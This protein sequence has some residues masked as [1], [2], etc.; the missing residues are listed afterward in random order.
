[1][2]NIFNIPFTDRTLSHDK[3]YID[4][5]WV[6]ADNHSSIAVT[7]PAN[8][9]VIG[10]VPNMGQA[11][12]ARAIASAYSAFAAWRRLTA[13]ARADLLKS[14]HRLILEHISDIAK[15]ITLEEGKPLA[16]STAEVRYG[17]S[18]IE[19]FAEE[20]KRVDGQFIP[21]FDQNKRIL[22]L[23]QPVG[24]VAAITP[25]NFPLA[26]ATRKLA[27]ALASGCT[28]VLK[29][30]E[31]TPFT[32]LAIAELAHR[33]GIPRGVLNVI[34]GEPIEIGKELTGNNLVRKVTFTGSTE[35]GKTIMSQCST[36]IK[37][38]SLELGGN[39][40][41][42]VFDDADIDLA[43]AGAVAAKF[44]NAGQTCICANRFLVQ[45]TVYD[46]FTS[47]LAHKVSSLKLGDGLTEGTQVGP[48]IN[49][50]AIGKVEHL[51]ADAMRKGARILIGGKR[52]P[53]CGTFYEPTIIA[54]VS[55]AMEILQTEIFGPV[56][57][58]MRFSTEAEALALANDTDYGLAAYFYTQD[59]GRAWR[60]AEGL[61]YGMVGINEGIIST[62]IAPFGGMK[63]SGIGREG[64]KTGIDEYVETKYLCIGGINA[65]A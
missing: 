16:E 61:E 47:R 25:W 9:E 22:T 33:A 20:G 64:A 51:V 15:L 52:H 59:I 58:I 17:A 40:P 43:V 6:E 21:T 44:R 30:A 19:W 1:M 24:V 49:E 35:V 23:K 42:I 55:L 60:F 54:D 5:C 11:E 27:P 50:K 29:P 26:M 57:P 8:A 65:S 41:F 4:G 2:N 36:S 53:A 39:A 7:N 28:V 14:W 32:A 45:E 13:N 37:N 62:E 63:Q 38:I 31:E 10:H 18:F 48:L 34:T 12:T 3:A 56:A 46:E